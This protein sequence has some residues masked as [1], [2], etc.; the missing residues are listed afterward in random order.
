MGGLERI[1]VR[2]RAKQHV[3]ACL[4]FDAIPACLLH[5]GRLVEN[6]NHWLGTWGGGI[7]VSIL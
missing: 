2:C 7:R 1:D 6:R 4:V 3:R 5:G